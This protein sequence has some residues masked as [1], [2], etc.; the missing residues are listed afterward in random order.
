MERLQFAY[1]NLCTLFSR[2]SEFKEFRMKN[3]RILFALSAFSTMLKVTEAIEGGILVTTHTLNSWCYNAGIFTYNTTT[4]RYK[5]ICAG[6]I[7][8]TKYILTSQ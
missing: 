5:Y 8:N 1:G 7:I 6:A 2:Y 4:S 3:L